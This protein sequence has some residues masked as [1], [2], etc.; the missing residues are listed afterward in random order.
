MFTGLDMSNIDQVPAYYLGRMNPRYLWLRPHSYF[1]LDCNK[2]ERLPFQG[3]GLSL[4]YKF[5]NPIIQQQFM[6]SG[7]LLSLCFQRAYLD[8]QKVSNKNFRHIWKYVFRVGPAIA[9]ARIEQVEIM[10]GNM[11]VGMTGKNT[12]T[13]ITETELLDSDLKYLYDRSAEEACDNV[14]SLFQIDGSS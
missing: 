5:A 3:L 10:T 4:N 8:I 12:W 6:D 9:E 13:Q 7:R 1:Y 2:I 11:V 14:E